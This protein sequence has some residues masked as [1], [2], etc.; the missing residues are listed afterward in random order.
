[1][2]R[3]PKIIQNYQATSSLWDGHRSI[4]I[5]RFVRSQGPLEAVR[6]GVRSPHVLYPRYLHASLGLC[7][8]SAVLR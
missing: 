5:G 4:I 1:M 6:K 7:H 3:F 8:Q 2:T